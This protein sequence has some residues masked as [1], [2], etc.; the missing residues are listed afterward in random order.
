MGN[1]HLQA[2]L[3]EQVLETREVNCEA[4]LP[5]VPWAT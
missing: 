1:L 2:V 5:L 4:V 3:A